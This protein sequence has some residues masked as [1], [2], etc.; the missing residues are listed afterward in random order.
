MFS[1]ERA[2]KYLARLAG[3]L[4]PLL[5]IVVVL[6]VLSNLRQTG[7]GWR[8]PEFWI[9]VAANAVLAFSQF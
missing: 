6:G 3:K 2:A 7:V 9:A 8:D 4:L 5:A 1:P